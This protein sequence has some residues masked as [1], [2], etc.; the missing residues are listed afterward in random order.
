[1]SVPLLV[2]A[3]TASKHPLLIESVSLGIMSR[4]VEL[5]SVLLGQVTELEIDDRLV[6]TFPYHLATTYLDGVKSCCL[7]IE[8]LLE[9]HIHP[10]DCYNNDKGHTILDS[11]M[12][13]ILRS[14]TSCKP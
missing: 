9:A 10:R 13:S 6:S 1:M 5:L 3:V 2:E 8:T 12:L 11:L 4:N 14:H 7:I